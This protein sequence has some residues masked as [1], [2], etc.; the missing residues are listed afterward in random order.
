MYIYNVFIDTYCTD[1]KSGRQKECDR[2]LQTRD[3]FIDF[4]SLCHI[5]F[6][7]LSG[8]SSWVRKTTVLSFLFCF[9]FD[10]LV[11]STH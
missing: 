11:F 10:F 8:Q 3:C 5:L 2:N 9:C 6:R 1:Y 4:V 7:L